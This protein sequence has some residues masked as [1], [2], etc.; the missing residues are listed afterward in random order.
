MAKRKTRQQ[1]IASD[2]RRPISGEST[3]VFSL[4]NSPKMPQ[5]TLVKTTTMHPYLIKDLKKTAI[6]TAM[7]VAFQF[8]LF[9]LLKNHIL[10]IPGLGY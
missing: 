5:K 8:S 6:L 7:I 10:R 2:Q 9:F 4:A 1:K 3:F